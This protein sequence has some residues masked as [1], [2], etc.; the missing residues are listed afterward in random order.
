[1]VLR[2]QLRKMERQDKGTWKTVDEHN[3]LQAVEGARKGLAWITLKHEE[4]KKKEEVN[5]GERDQEDDG[6]DT[7]QIEG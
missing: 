5:Q 7:D 6:E 2:I 3:F 4:E 1:M